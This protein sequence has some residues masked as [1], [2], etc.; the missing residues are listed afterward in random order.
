MRGDVRRHAAQ[1]ECI[2]GAS[3]PGADHDDVGAHGP[4]RSDNLLRRIAP[5]QN[6]PEI[7]VP[8]DGLFALTNVPDNM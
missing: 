2:D 7:P 1:E 8:A 4:G 6:P 3:P 5:I